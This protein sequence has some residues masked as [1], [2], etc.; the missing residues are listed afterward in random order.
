MSNA[1][2]INPVVF[3]YFKQIYVTILSKD[4]HFSWNLMNV[5]QVILQRRI[6][7]ERLGTHHALRRR[8]LVDVLEVDFEASL[9]GE[10]LSTLDAR[11]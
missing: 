4:I 7:F 6:V 8:C 9:G 11:K 3:L 1:V 5:F 10:Q 2:V